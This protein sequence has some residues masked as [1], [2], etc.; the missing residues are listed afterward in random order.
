[1]LSSEGEDLKPV[2]LKQELR[3]VKKYLARLGL[4]NDSSG[5]V[6]YYGFYTGGKA[7][8]AFQTIEREEVNLTLPQ[9][10]HRLHQLFDSST[11]TD[12]TYHEWQNI[13][14]TAGI[15][16]KKSSCAPSLPGHAVRRTFQAL[17]T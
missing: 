1:M 14:Q 16:A 10:T 5:V 17:I 4:N 7:N 3:T 9:L 6:D 12:D 13:C 15:S 2:K 8:N 11:N